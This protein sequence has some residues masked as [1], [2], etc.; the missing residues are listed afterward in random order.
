MVLIDMPMPTRCY[1]C[2]LNINIGSGD[3]NTVWACNL[4]GKPVGEHGEYVRRPKWCPL[5]EVQ[6]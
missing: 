5:K 1:T 6:E 2:P 3:G 4:N